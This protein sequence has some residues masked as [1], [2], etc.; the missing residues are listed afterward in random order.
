MSS[1]KRFVWNFSC[2]QIF[3]EIFI[4]HYNS[5]YFIRRYHEYENQKLV[6][7]FV[8]N[9]SDRV[10]DEHLVAILF[11]VALWDAKLL[12]KRVICRAWFGLEISVTYIFSLSPK[13]LS[14]G[15][16]KINDDINKECFEMCLIK[17]DWKISLSFSIYLFLQWLLR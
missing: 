14:I 17:K 1:W 2:W 5:D 15:Q 16:K 9:T 7:K 3:T 13:R 4:K 11:Q 10:H 8:W 12:W 6:M